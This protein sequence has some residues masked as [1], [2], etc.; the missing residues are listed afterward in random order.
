MVDKK[1][2]RKMSAEQKKA[3]TV[4]TLDATVVLS[5]LDATKRVLKIILNVCQNVINRTR[6]QSNLGD[7]LCRGAASS[8]DSITDY[9]EFYSLV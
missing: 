5:T 9:N 4:S 3:Y 2:N 6:Q 7:L 8:V 1:Q